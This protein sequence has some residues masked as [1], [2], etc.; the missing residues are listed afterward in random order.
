MFM[1]NALGLNYRYM[2]Q[3]QDSSNVE[4]RRWGF[5]VIIKLSTAAPHSHTSE[6][7]IGLDSTSA[8]TKEQDQAIRRSF[9][10]VWLSFKSITYALFWQLPGT[11]MYASI[12]YT[13]NINPCSSMHIV[14]VSAWQRKES[15]RQQFAHLPL[16]FLLH[17]S[18]CN[19]KKWLHIPKKIVQVRVSM[20]CVYFIIMA[21]FMASIDLMAPK[22]CR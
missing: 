14:C 6:T 16:N 20:L 1:F 9:F 17:P 8:H 19:N 2:V 5:S 11:Y 3:S 13:C 10:I 21:Y 22:Q 4:W 7:L 12:Q 15:M 18:T